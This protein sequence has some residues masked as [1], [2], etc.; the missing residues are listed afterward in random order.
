MAATITN[1]QAQADQ[2]LLQNYS[3]AAVLINAEGDIIYI[4]GRTGK[5]LEPAMGKANWNIHAMAREKLQHQLYLAINQAQQQIEPVHIPNLI[6]DHVTFNLTVHAMTKPKALLGLLMVLFT[7]VATPA[8]S[9]RKKR[10]A[11]EQDALL[12]LQ[13]AH[14]ENQLLREKIQT[15]Q[16]DLKSSNDAMQST[17]Q[18]LQVACEELITSKEEMQSMSE[19][20]HI[21]NAELQTKFCDLSSLNCDMRH[22]LDNTEIATVFL[23]RKL[24]VRRFT[25]HAADLF[26]L[27]QSD[28]GRPLSDIMT[29]LDY[30][31]LQQDAKEVLRTLVRIEKE[32]MAESDRWF[33]VRIMLSR[34]QEN[35]IDGVVITFIDITDSK[36]VKMGLENSEKELTKS[37]EDLERIFNLSAYMVCIASSEGYFLRISSAFTETLG[38]SEKEF[39][40]HPFV[41]FVHPADRESTI[42]NME[43]LA[44]GIPIIRF[45]NRYRCKDG[46]YKWLEWTARSFVNG[47]DIYAIAYDVTERKAVDA[48]LH[49]ALALVHDQRNELNVTSSLEAVLAKVQEVLE[50]DVTAQPSELSPD[51]AE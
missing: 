36:Q 6:V 23:D 45:P 2:I 49:D 4:N 29:Q 21:V 1:L 16:R 25:L 17:N 37:L 31:E 12:E 35:V 9:P 26:K 8:K 34:T 28:L 3:P 41:D 40:A 13:Q 38:F 7:D 46:S 27:I 33:K 24:H 18:A 48:M 20:L 51:K 19:E 15:A 32:V 39:L 44:R 11:A 14:S 30:A 10:Q 50:H 42:A 47:E 5:Y 43:P 22:L